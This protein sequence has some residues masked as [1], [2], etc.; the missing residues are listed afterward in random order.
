MGENGGKYLSQ[1][2]G[3]QMEKQLNQTRGNTHII[4]Y[5]V[6]ISLK[7]GKKE[8]ASNRERKERERERE[9][10]QRGAG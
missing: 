4:K 8:P 2:P 3:N 1:V 6:T 10:E 5:G 9:G 7:K